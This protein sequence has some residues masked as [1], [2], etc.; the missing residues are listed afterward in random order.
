MSPSWLRALEKRHSQENRPC[1]GPPPLFPEGAGI[2]GPPQETGI[3][4]VVDGA[5]PQ[6]L[7]MKEGGAELT[8]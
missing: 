1:G 2:Q 6:R 3:L 8:E 5:L 7:M 4:T